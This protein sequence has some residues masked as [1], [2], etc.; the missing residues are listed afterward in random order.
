[1]EKSLSYYQ[2][3]IGEMMANDVDAYDVF[4]EVD[5]MFHGDIELPRELRDL[6]DLRL[7][8]D[9]SPHDS[10]YNATVALANSQLSLTVTPLGD[11][12]AEFMR[13]N[14]MEQALQWNWKRAN[15][16][17]M[18]RKI[19][20]IAH[21]AI[22]YDLCITRVDDLYFYLPKDPAKWTKA[23]RRAARAGRFVITVLPPHK[24]HFQ[25][26]ELA[27]AFCVVSA[28]N[29]P[30]PK[31]VEY[32]EGIAGTDK[33][34]MQI[35][36]TV[37]KIRADFADDAAGFEQARFMLYQYIDD[38][39]RLDYGHIMQGMEDDETAGGESDYVFIDAENKL[40]FIPYTVRGGASDVESEPEHTYHPMLASAHWF[41]LW[42]NAILTKS[43]VFSDILRRIRELRG[44]YEGTTTDAVPP[45]D[46]T[47]GDKAL[48]PGTTYRRQPPTN[49][50]PQALQLVDGIANDLAATTSASALGNLSR[51]SNTA[52]STM[53]AIVQVE[54]GK[55]N[56][57]KNII[58]DT[59]S[60]QCYLFCEW[61]K[62]T[63][64]PLQAWRTE[65]GRVGEKDV[66]YGEE[67]QIKDSDYSLDSLFISAAITPETPT[68]QLQK[69]TIAE[70]LVALGMSA[71]EALEMMNVPHAGLQKDKR[72]LEL[73]K[74]GVLQATIEKIRAK[75]VGEVELMLQQK[76]AEIQQKQDAA[77]L[78]AQQ[79]AQGGGGGGQQPPA[80]NP[81][82]GAGGM[83][84]AAGGAPIQA[85][86]GMGREQMTGQARN[87][88]DVAV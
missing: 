35:K 20:G 3:K 12:E 10:L 63:K 86:P 31:V 21:S 29:M 41:D 24:V 55:L 65:K 57:Q 39:K 22:R 6:D 81:F 64:K 59:I 30:L 72:S 56:P 46:G 11:A 18:G 4:Y 76:A 61:T 26:S 9:S 82:A 88:M 42:R 1:M 53:N 84:S 54:M 40:P 14:R 48:P 68:D 23:N 34:G 70:N 83:D 87:G 25:V 49:V 28:R 80:G 69:M 78:A 52:F 85:A 58:Q 51:Y 74:D 15:M 7:I 38:D 45:D 79:G 75:L 62:F 32:Y 77:A 73:L 66:S 60:D 2:S 44:T 8:K 71:E 27:G 17:G 13:A 37:E 50:D 67:I 33:V 19:W 47:G 5:K 36:A 16:R 43:L